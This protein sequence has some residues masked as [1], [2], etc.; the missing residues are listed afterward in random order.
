MKERRRCLTTGRRSE[1]KTIS[2]QTNS[3]IFQ[4]EIVCH[5]RL[6]RGEDGTEAG[7][8]QHTIGAIAVRWDI[9]TD[10]VEE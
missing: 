8:S 3:K 7:L 9:R 6:A 2:A 1:Q 5:S 10:K 4:G